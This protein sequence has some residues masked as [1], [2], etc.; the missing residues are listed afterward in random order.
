MTVDEL[1]AS[2]LTQSDD[3][4]DVITGDVTTEDVP[5]VKKRKQFSVW[6]M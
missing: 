4:D 1:L 6:R 2:D 3:D 5:H